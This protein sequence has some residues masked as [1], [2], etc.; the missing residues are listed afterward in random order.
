M[1]SSYATDDESIFDIHPDSHAGPGNNR[2]MLEKLSDVSG[3]LQAFEDV[4]CRA[5]V[6]YRSRRG[7]SGIAAGSLRIRV[8]CASSPHEISRLRPE[9][10]A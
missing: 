3:T 2:S 4:L 5:S 10:E 8:A 9:G 7:V 1:L 6:G